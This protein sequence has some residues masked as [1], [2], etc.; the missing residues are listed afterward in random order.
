MVVQMLTRIGVAFQAAIQSRACRV[1]L[2]T[3]SVA[4]VQLN[5]QSVVAK[6]TSDDTLVFFM[7]VKN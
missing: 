4:L 5:A 3:T 6:R 7:R 2:F 1:G